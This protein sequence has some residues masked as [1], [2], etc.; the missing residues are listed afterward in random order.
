MK[1]NM[2]KTIQRKAK[3]ALKSQVEVMQMDANDILGSP[4]KLISSSKGYYL[5][6]NPDHV[7]IFNA[8]IFADDE[9][10]WYGDL[11]L[12]DN[13]TLNKLARLSSHLDKTVLVLPEMSG[14]FEM[15][16]NPDFT[17]TAMEFHKGKISDYKS[18]Y[19]TLKDNQYVLTTPRD[20]DLTINHEGMPIPFNQP[21][22]TASCPI[23]FDKLEP[24]SGEETEEPVYKLAKQ[25]EEKLEFDMSEV[26]LSVTDIVVNNVCYTR[27][28][29]LME[30]YL[31]LA[32][33]DADE[34]TRHKEWTFYNFNCAPCMS[35][36][37]FL[38]DDTVYI[39]DVKL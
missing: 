35:N 21:E 28:S 25:L 27:I 16:Q 30:K 2:L 9:K 17:T 33:P 36:A 19:I 26:K 31:D 5:H 14:R 32:L 11:D 12:S 4:G 39:R 13:T 38:D 15:E 3:T 29:Q 6:N 18:D 24:K 7:V 20:T 10:I 34:Y 22:I 8:N 23:D 1:D 37:E